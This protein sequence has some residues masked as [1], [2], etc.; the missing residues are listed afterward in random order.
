MRALVE[1]GSD[2]KGR[3]GRHMTP[4]DLCGPQSGIAKAIKEGLGVRWVRET[5]RKLLVLSVLM[6]N[7]E[8]RKGRGGKSGGGD[9]VKGSE[10]QEGE[11]EE[12]AK[13]REN[14]EID[15]NKRGRKG[16]KNEKLSWR[17]KRQRKGKPMPVLSFCV[18]RFAEDEEEEK[19]CEAGEG[20]KNGKEV[21]GTNE[22]EHINLKRTKHQQQEEEE[23]N[24]EGRR[25]RRRKMTRVNKKEEGHIRVSRLVHLLFVCLPQDM[26]RAV[27]SFV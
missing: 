1:L 11:E 22:E 7:E 6:G 2:V 19:G 13:E 15:N 18:G 21:G 5:M 3:D 16:K 27:V 12:G 10:E 25:R 24:L 20:V 26:R 14:K 8:D 23:D 9:C 17:E 4:L